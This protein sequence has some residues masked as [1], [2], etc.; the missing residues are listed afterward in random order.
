MV[1]GPKK[2]PDFFT[3]VFGGFFFVVLVVVLV[4]FVVT[5]CAIDIPAGMNETA[6][7]IPQIAVVFKNL[8][9]GTQ[10]LL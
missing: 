7:P 8:L 2:V 5:A 1:E 6:A 9:L 3:V 10:I 4:V